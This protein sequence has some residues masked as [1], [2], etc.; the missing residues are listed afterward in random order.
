MNAVHC[1]RC[2]APLPPPTAHCPAHALAKSCPDSDEQ[3]FREEEEEYALRQQQQEE[4]EEAEA[5][6]QQQQQ[7]QQQQAQQQQAQQAPM[8]DSVYGGS[9][10]PAMGLPATV[11]LGY[12]NLDPFQWAA[13]MSHYAPAQ[14]AVGGQGQGSQESVLPK[15]KW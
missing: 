4:A 2:H 10:P 14:R 9:A 11:V 7:A 12:E 5:V 8:P 1:R 3:R 13:L 6:A 15:P